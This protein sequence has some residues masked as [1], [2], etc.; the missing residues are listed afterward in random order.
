[1]QKLYGIFCIVLCT[2]A[3]YAPGVITRTTNLSATQ[4]SEF[5]KMR[6]FNRTF[7]TWKK[8]LTKAQA[9]HMK[10]LFDMY[11]ATYL[12]YKKNPGSADDYSIA[13]SVMGSIKN[14]MENWDSFYRDYMQVDIFAGK[15]KELKARLKPAQLM[16]IKNSLN[17]YETL[18]G[19]Y[20][21]EPTNKKYLS[22]LQEQQ[23]VLEK[24][25][26]SMNL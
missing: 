1:M 2:A 7:E 10:D 3:L 22:D 15:I 21:K 8:R 11:E 17:V 16:K 19:R 9:Q 23:Q 20:E 13:A 26:S 5:E 14:L 24:L 18:Y 4:Q 6:V 12:E 25:I